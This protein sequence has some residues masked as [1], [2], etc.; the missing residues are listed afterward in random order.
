MKRNLLLSAVLASALGA[1]ALP[2]QTTTIT[3]DGQFAAG[4]KW[5]TLR[6][7]SAGYYIHDNGTDA[8]YLPLDAITTDYADSDLW[9]FTGNDTDGYQI[10]NKAAGALKMLAGPTSV[11]SD[12]NTGGSSYAI[13][14]AAGDAS[15]VYQWQFSASTNLGSDVEAYYLNL[16]GIES[17][18]MNNRSSKVA[19]WTSGK[20]AGSSVRIA[21]GPETISAAAAGTASPW[22]I[23]LDPQITLSCDGGT[24]AN[25]CELSAGTW[26][27]NTP[28]GY[29]IK[30]AT[31]TDANGQTVTVSGSG[32]DNSGMTITG[33]ATVKNLNVVYQPTVW[34]NHGKVIFRYDGS[35]GYTTVYRI[36]SMLT[37]EAGEKA[38]RIIAIND[39]R[40]N[41]G[42]IGQGG[43]IDLRMS[44]SDDQGKTWST[45][46]VFRDSSGNA[47]SQG[48]GSG[49]A[50]SH[51]FA[52]GDAASVSDRETGKI[53][54]MSV[55]GNVLFWSGRRA[56]PNLVTRWYSEDGGQTFTPV[57]EIT[58]DIFKLFD[59]TCPWG[60]IDS[61]FIG[62]GRIM[63]SRYIKVGDYYR[64]Y[65]AN[66]IY[67]N[68]AGITAN[69]VLYSDDFGM[70]WN[71]LGGGMAP[72]VSVSGDEPK[73]E[74]LPDGSVLLAAR[75]NGGNRNFNIFRYTNAA[76]GEG[77]WSNSVNT[78]LGAGT[79][80]N[81]C[82]GEIMI[83]PVRSTTDGSRCY[84]ALQSFP[85]SSSRIKVSIAWKALKNGDDIASPS[86]FTTWD[87]FN[88]ITPLSSAYST[89][90]LQSDN[91]IGFLYEEGTY[92][93]SYCGVYQN[94]TIEDLTDGQ[95]EYCAD[96]DGSVAKAI[97]LDLMQKRI[98]S[99]APVSDEKGKYL[100]QPTGD[101]CPAANAAFSAYQASGNHEDY[102]AFNL[103]LANNDAIITPHTN[104]IYTFLSANNYSANAGTDYYL[105]ATRNQ[106]AL[107]LAKSAGKVAQWTLKPVEGSTDSWHLF[108]ALSEKYIAELP[109]ATETAISTTA[110]AAAAG[111]FRLVSTVEGKTAICG[112][113]RN[114][115]Y[116]A[117]HLKSGNTFVIWT[118]DNTNSQW[119]AS[120]VGEDASSI[121]EVG[122]EIAPNQVR[123]YDLTGSEVTKPVSGNLYITGDRRKVIY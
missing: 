44:Y 114:A 36:P 89:M 83:L 25:G 75:G 15:Y 55:A 50:S 46:D 13:L 42:D 97:T 103:A 116:P 38:G 41:G 35:S 27:F 14:K 2:F 10:Y 86:C 28:D 17:A 108:N 8:T 49:S 99:E 117:I 85:R 113:G 70:T 11:T 88:E 6:L 58:E 57:Q 32:E 107:Y 33:P 104:G 109:T 119:Y 54:V 3:A 79:S 24:I 81:A 60:Y 16:K 90:C 43:R 72:A 19:F 120:L 45:P 110:D 123:L 112:V 7:A 4:T 5:Y 37:V 96:E 53:L 71:I 78:N 66:S 59:N 34:I 93:Y 40:F 21:P 111:E 22:V 76:K 82:D 94:F 95:Y 102:Y 105:G 122:A 9:C 87:G 92:G 29:C 121:E 115:T 52:Y 101:G 1:A 39:Y 23:S 12:G 73:A 61:Q 100:G 69:F 98:D 47:V 30:T 56:A 20:D 63:Q 91:T 65:A 26:Q 74:E 84:V 106:E 48:T 31:Y 67:N 68:A 18:V 80:I 118:S 64:I 62:S 51:T 77:S